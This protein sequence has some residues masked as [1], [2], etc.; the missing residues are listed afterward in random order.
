M[1]IISLIRPCMWSGDSPKRRRILSG[2]RAVAKYRANAAYRANG[3]LIM[4][5]REMI[6]RL[7]SGFSGF[8]FYSY[9]SVYGDV[10]PNTI[11][12]AERSQGCYDATFQALA[13]GL[14]SKLKEVRTKHPNSEFFDPLKIPELGWL[15]ERLDRGDTLPLTPGDLIMDHEDRYLIEQYGIRLAVSPCVGETAMIER[16][17]QSPETFPYNDLASVTYDVTFAE[18][19]RRQKPGF[20]LAYGTHNG[21][22]RALEPNERELNDD[23]AY[24]LHKRNAVFEPDPR[25]A[26]SHRLRLLVFGGYGPGDET[27]HFSMDQAALYQNV[28]FT[29]DLE[30]YPEKA[31]TKEPELIIVPVLRDRK[32]DCCDIARKGQGLP[33]YHDT[34]QG[35]T[36]QWAFKDLMN[37]LIC[38][39]WEIDHTQIGETDRRSLNNLINIMHDQ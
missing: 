37:V 23:K 4:R 5:L 31:L 7:E 18:D 34:R 15:I 36:W 39:R 19:N 1:D 21:R 33:V 32:Y 26:A 14:S 35:M 6:A 17:G 25:V 12:S 22:I 13:V 9:I 29:L 2:G 20:R 10:S 8:K 30:A 28:A 11:R 3:A 24:R 16:S 27:A 38:I